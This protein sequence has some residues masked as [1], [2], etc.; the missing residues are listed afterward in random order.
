MALAVWRVNG[1]RIS[2]RGRNATLS[3]IHFGYAAEGRLAWI[4]IMVWIQSA[5][6]GK[7]QVHHCQSGMRE[8]WMLEVVSQHGWVLWLLLVSWCMRNIVLHT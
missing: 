3:L 6:P 8:H 1:G 7:V 4:R 5:P 2:Q